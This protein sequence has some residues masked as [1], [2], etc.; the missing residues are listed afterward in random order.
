MS[1]TGRARLCGPRLTGSGRRR[2]VGTVL[3]SLAVVVAT[4][5]ATAG[6]TAAAGILPPANPAANIPM[7]TTG[8]CQAGPD[9]VPDSSPTCIGADLAAV[10]AARAAEGVGP[11]ILPTD[12]ADLSGPE[13]LFVVTN[14]ER[15]DRGVP[16]MLGLTDPLNALAAEGATAGT[17]PPFPTE[18]ITWGGAVWAGG[19][20]STLEAEYGW[21][22]DDG[23]GSNNLDCGVP[24]APGCWGHR[25]VLLSAPDGAPLVAGAADATGPDGPQYAMVLAQYI[26]TPPTLSYTWA[27]ALANGA[28]LA[29]TPPAGVVRLA[30]TDRVATAD[31]V[32]QSTW[33]DV[34]Q[35]GTHA[36]SAVIAR[37][38][39]FSDALA[40]VPLAAAK[41][42]P[43]LLTTPASLDPRTLA[44]IERI[45]PLGATV[46]LVGG[47]AA[48]SP[49]IAA[50]L[51]RAG[52]VPERLAGLDRFAT[53]TAVAGALGNP[54]T[55]FEADGEDFADA[56]AAG[57]AA[58]ALHGAVLLTDGT[59]QSTST[60]A[61]LSRHHPVA[62]AIGG[63]A[64]AADRAAHA[65]VGSDRFDTAA[66]VAQ[67]FFPAPPRIGI[68]TGFDYPD[69]LAAGAQL[70]QAGGPLLLVAAD[71]PVPAPTLRY[72]GDH[73]SATATLYGGLAAVPSA[74]A[75]S[76]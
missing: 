47:N 62:Y 33:G 34:G 27:D 18:G 65:V 21:M 69:A 74:V 44:E 53:A 22:Y 6:P 17:D 64:A 13:Q 39:A 8:P 10:N 72:L 75:A 3:G 46:Y 9:S 45:L 68:A 2:Y 73:R 16:A 40:A 15:V 24:S 49:Q 19:F 50:A 51:T 7:S 36:S 14:L 11:M 76:L 58:A 48:L 25:D 59:T 60:A 5:M 43:L 28:G 35:S 56:L 70:A 63:P 29:P 61:Y 66:R 26:G 32:S 31:V 37:C 20:D 4:T 54:G 42:G 41:G 57:P 52:Y 38:D 30:G 12:Y 23:P 55:V 71:P 1:L 67:A